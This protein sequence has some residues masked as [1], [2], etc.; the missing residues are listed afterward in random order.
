MYQKRKQLRIRSKLG[1]LAGNGVL[2]ANIIDHCLTTGRPFFVIA[3]EGHTSPATV[4]RRGGSDVPHAWVRLG[5]AGAAIRILR[6]QRVEEL[7]MAGGIRRPSFSGLRPDLWTAR[8]LMRAGVGTRG[9][10]A[11]LSAIV[12]ALEGEGFRVVGADDVLPEVLAPDGVYGRVSPDDQD[13]RDIE[14]GIE[15]ARGIGAE[16][17]GQAAIVRRGQIVALETAAGTDAMLADCVA[18]RPPDRGGVLVKVKTPGQERRADLPTIGV[19]TIEAVDRAGLSGVAVEAFGALVLNREA[20]V[21]AAD[22]AGLFV[23]GVAADKTKDRS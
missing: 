5:A 10:D 22:S 21:A 2:P 17:I 16:D 8:F 6:K 13:M 1:V 15:A 23:M 7:V 19:R 3:F 20:V 11:L 18:A 12:R 14:Q 4:E 9:D